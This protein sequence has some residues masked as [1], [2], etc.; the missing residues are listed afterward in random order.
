MPPLSSG[1]NT[2]LAVLEHVADEIGEG[3]LAGQDEGDRPRE[4]A[5]HQQRAEHEFDRAGAPMRISGG[6]ANMRHDRKLEDLGDAVLKQQQSGD[7]A[8]QTQRHRLKSREHPVELVHVIVPL[9]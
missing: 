4:Q 1:K 7:E 6:L 8:K 5:D 3:H 9:V 2:G